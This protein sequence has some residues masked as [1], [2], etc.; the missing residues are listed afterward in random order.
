M[1]QKS[2]ASKVKDSTTNLADL[3]WWTA[4]Q[5]DSYM[6]VVATD[7]FNNHGQKHWRHHTEEILITQHGVTSSRIWWKNM[8]EMTI[9]IMDYDGSD[10]KPDPLCPVYERIWF[11]SRRT[12]CIIRLQPW[13]GNHWIHILTSLIKNIV[14][15]LNST[16][17]Y[18]CNVTFS[19]ATMS[20]F[21]L[22][23]A[24]SCTLAFLRCRTS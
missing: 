2:Q 17:S 21:V 23:S 18:R 9:K 1:L 12:Q 3:D 7:V 11:G 19:I 22:S 5:C 8:E 16:G 24:I 10:R 20:C 15:S 14:N 6:E 13:N 4:S